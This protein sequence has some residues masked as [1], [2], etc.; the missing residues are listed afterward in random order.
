[1]SFQGQKNDLT[2][3]RNLEGLRKNKESVDKI[4]RDMEELAE[5]YRNQYPGSEIEDV[6]QDMRDDQYDD[7]AEY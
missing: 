7:E 4:M 6:V 5:Q 3:N 1:M 2:Y